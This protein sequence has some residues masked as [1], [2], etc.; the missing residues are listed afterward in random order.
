MEI[1][2][3]RHI[4]ITPEVRGGRP[5]LAG[6]RITVAD[7]VI[8]HLRM[9]LSLEEIAGKYEL[10]FASVYAAIAYY[11]DHRSEIDESIDVQDN[12]AESFR[13]N[14]PSQLQDKLT[15]PHSD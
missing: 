14:N 13:Q 1:V 10:D 15:S 4:E 8:M 2:L 12:F 7:V 6:T 11:Y 5:R 3:D 9:G